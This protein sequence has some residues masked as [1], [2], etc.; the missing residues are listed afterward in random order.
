MKATIIFVM[1]AFALAA[2]Y[3]ADGFVAEPGKYVDV[4]KDGQ[5]RLRYVHAFDLSTPETTHDTYKVFC[6]VLGPDGK[7]PITKGPGGKFTH[8]RGIFLGWSKIKFGEKSYDLWHMKNGYLIHKG[9]G[10]MKTGTDA[11][12][13][14]AKISWETAEGVKILSDLQRF[15]HSSSS[16]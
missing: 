7:T 3:A 8:H 1:A 5:P 4:M 15:S 2:G 9:F 11:N 14:V 6:H 13:M 12:E 16:F 10:E